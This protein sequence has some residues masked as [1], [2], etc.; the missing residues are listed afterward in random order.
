MYS[1]VRVE[2]KEVLRP[3]PGNTQRLSKGPCAELRRSACPRR[4]GLPALGE[5]ACL[6]QERRPACPRRGGLPAL[7]EQIWFGRQDWSRVIC[8]APSKPGTVACKDE[9]RVSAGR[10]GNSKYRSGM[11]ILRA[12][13]VVQSVKN[14]PA[15]A[16]DMGSIP[17]LGRSSGEG[18]GNPLLYSCL[19]NP[20]DRGAWQATVH[21][22]AKS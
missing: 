17:G 7:G 11:L 13:L 14:P 22:V 12:S 3:W 21:G 10:W 6:P 15:N 1:L 9:G 16:G 2:V 8:P 19:G 20:M 5:E 18:N 4:G